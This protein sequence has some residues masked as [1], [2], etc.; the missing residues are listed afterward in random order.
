MPTM[1]TSGVLRGDA[2][3][4]R[5]RRSLCA[6]VVGWGALL[7][8][9]GCSGGYDA[10]PLPEGSPML[11]GDELCAFDMEPGQGDRCSQDCLTA[12]CGGSLGKR[13]CT[14]EGGVFLQCACLPPD[15]WPYD[16]V[17]AVPYCDAISGRP[18]NLVGEVCT[19]EGEECRS[20]HAPEQ[21]CTCTNGFWVCGDS[22]GL[23]EGARACEDF[24]SGLGRRLDKK[25]C[26]AEWDL[27]INRD[28]NAT[29]TSPRGCMC[30]A[31]GAQFFW[32]CGATN[33]WYRA[34]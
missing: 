6:A 9:A 8:A 16:H 31:Q 19:S 11:K 7:V 23:A 13:I 3:S 30:L 18:P 10:A 14:C 34:E 2:R 22:A 29:G 12:T 25:P 28:F 32:K 26:D 15:N 4:T 24:G 21:G 33:R 1:T 17:P 20:S 27:C 5:L